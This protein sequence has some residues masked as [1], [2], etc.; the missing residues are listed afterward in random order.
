MGFIAY[1]AGQYAY[2]V[3]MWWYGFTMSGLVGM[4]SLDTAVRP[5][6]GG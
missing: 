2:F 1:G 4:N 5:G 3:I 6:M